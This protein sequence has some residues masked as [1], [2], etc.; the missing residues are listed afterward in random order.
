MVNLIRAKDAAITI[1]LGLLIT[2]TARNR[3][4]E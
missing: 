2:E 1:A 3:T 4:G